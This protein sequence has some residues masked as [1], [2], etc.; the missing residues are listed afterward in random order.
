VAAVGSH[1]ITGQSGKAHNIT[2]R[3]SKIFKRK[4]SGSKSMMD[5]KEKKILESV[6]AQIKH[7]KSIKKTGN[8]KITV[9]LNM[10]QGNIGSAN[11]ENRN[12][13]I[14]FQA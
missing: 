2:N 11:I 4:W 14:I 12:K 9:E 3:T 1:D 6:F 7:L 5:E 13:E 10:S 8:I